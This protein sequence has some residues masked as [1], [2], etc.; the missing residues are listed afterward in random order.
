MKSEENSLHISQDLS[1]TLNDLLKFPLIEA[2][3]GRRSR[4]FCL[5]AE[6]P[7]GVLSFKSK[8]EPLPLNEIE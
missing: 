2:I 6:I 4:R 5:G 7:D 3:R 8:H 1:E